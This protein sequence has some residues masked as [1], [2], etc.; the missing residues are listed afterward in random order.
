M[1]MNKTK[2]SRLMRFLAL[3]LLFPAQAVA[4]PITLPVDLS[5]GRP[6]VS[7]QL[8]GEPV[9]VIFDTGG[10][11]GANSGGV[12]AQAAERLKLP[13][14]GKS[15]VNSPAGGTA[16]EVDVHQVKSLRFGSYEAK[17]LSLARGGPGMPGGDILVGNSVFGRSGK[18]M[19]LD[20]AAEQ[21]RLVDVPTVTVAQW[22]P[23]APNGHLHTTITIGGKS[24]P[25]AI[26][27]GFPRQL[28][29]P[30]SLMEEVPLASAPRVV[31]RARTVNSEFE[32]MGADVTAEVSI[33][34]LKLPVSST[35]FGPFPRV[36]VGTAAIKDFTIVIDW[37]NK[38]F[39]IIESKAA[40]AK[41]I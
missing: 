11:N 26:D 3:A 27:T 17:N 29:I 31:G 34:D 2:V 35:L 24:Y 13:V 9:K 30:K 15:K 1:N 20:L 18:I 25:A 16:A 23:L 14:T 5:S 33:G 8:N 22:Y 36:V 12:S 4:E 19:E 28:T 38:R 6:I 39:G 40:A 7:A 21:L 10:P 41:P 37:K 32:V